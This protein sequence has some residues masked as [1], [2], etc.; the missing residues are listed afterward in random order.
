MN[1]SMNKLWCKN[2]TKEEIEDELK[3]QLETYD[4][5]TLINLLSERLSNKEKRN[6]VNQY[7]KD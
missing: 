1:Y 4:K 6:W 5:G 2:K 3:R 7:Y